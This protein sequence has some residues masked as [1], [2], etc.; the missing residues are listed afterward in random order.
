MRATRGAAALLSAVACL[1]AVAYAAAPHRSGSPAL[2]RE[3]GP[4]AASLPRPSITSHPDKLSTST[5]AGFS[6]SA[7]GGAQRFQ[8]RL[9]GR[10]WTP[11]RSPATYSRLATGGHA[12]SV[13]ALGR[14]GK[15]G[16]GARFRWRIMEPKDF[17]IVPRLDG[18]G[19]LYPGAPPLPLPLT[20]VNPNPA[21]IFLTSLRVSAAGGPLECASADNLVL[22]SSSA[23]ASA[24]IKVPAGGSV[25]LP[26]Q[27]ASPPAIQLR[28]L[29]V[30]QDACQRAQFPLTFSGKAR[31]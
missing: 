18:L 14:A 20:I 21:P 7:R 10:A 19:A 5:S 12:F 4:G 9:D 29:P 13:R 30:N 27:G 25:S 24:P 3:R 15:H 6:F 1:S 11:C 17:A 28:D 26:G 23:S 31:G 16:R 22:T 8:C 2:S